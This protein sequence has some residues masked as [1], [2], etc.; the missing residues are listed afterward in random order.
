MKPAIF[1]QTSLET[2]HLAQSERVMD[3]HIHSNEPYLLAAR[4][5]TRNG[6]RAGEFHLL[7]TRVSQ[8]MGRVGIMA[9]LYDP[10]NEEPFLL[11]EGSSHQG[12]ITPSR[13]NGLHV[14][15]PETG[16]LGIIKEGYLLAH[17][18]IPARVGRSALHS[19][20]ESAYASRATGGEY[21][22]LSTGSF[23]FHGVT[24]GYN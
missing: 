23:E 18:E 3:D 2:Y 17:P 16:S 15:H 24:L 20:S 13:E 10:S 12:M 21:L 7:M 1:K 11:I 22:D 9:H 6:S 8:E 19:L 5:E 14:T 4:L